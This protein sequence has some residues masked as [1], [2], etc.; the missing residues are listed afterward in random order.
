MIKV[1]RPASFCCLFF[2]LWIHS[3]ALVAVAATNSTEES[4]WETQAEQND[5]LNH[6][7]QNEFSSPRESTTTLKLDFITIPLDGKISPREPICPP[8]LPA[9]ECFNLYYFT[10]DHYDQ[11]NGNRQ[12]ILYIGGGPGRTDTFF[13]RG[14]FSLEVNNNVIYFHLRGAGL[15]V[16]PPSN[17]YD[18]YLR[19]E[20]AVEDLERLRRK[21]LATSPG[22][23][24][25]WDAV[26]GASYG[27]VLA[28]RYAN[29]YPGSIKKL[30]LQSPIYRSK[31]TD[32]ARRGQLRSNLKNMFT[33]IRSKE[34]VP[35]SCTNTNLS[36]MN[37][38]ITN[39]SPRD[40]DA[41]NNFC[42]L[43]SAPAHKVIDNLVE[44]V[45]QEYDKIIEEYGALSLIIE[46]FAAFKKAY[47]PSYPDEFYYALRKL[48][49]VGAP[50][51]TDSTFTGGDVEYMVDSALVLG[52]YASLERQE[53]LEEQ[54]HKFAAC[55]DTG[56]IF[57]NVQG[58]SCKELYCKRLT[59]AKNAV[60]NKEKLKL[61]IQSF[62]R[63]LYVFGL[64]DGLQQ[65]ITR[66]FREEGVPMTN[67]SCPLGKTFVD[68]AQSTSE[69]HKLLRQ[70][71]RKIGI[72]PVDKYCLWNPKNF[73]H[74][75]PTL[76]LTGGADLNTAGC[77][78]ED[79]F[80]HGLDKK[81]ST[82][83]EFPTLGHTFKIPVE[84]VRKILG[85]K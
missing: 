49:N 78:A 38:H 65:W 28:Q 42:Y 7:K 61:E 6:F 81:K 26:Y 22:Q 59:E 76:I 8:Q 58:A 69:S 52:Y 39:I 67:E 45:L 16:V 21:I 12:N 48:D 72:I 46:N 29:K 66:M 71:V 9:S 37:V 10:G 18:K 13:D 63:D 64:S 34:S 51:N 56:T 55:S 35:C 43:D 85:E 47:R 50:Q 2:I 84:I 20:Y 14:L 25:Q 74:G 32:K 82:F 79:F 80:D 19:S 60:G 15:S 23:A 4:F 68:F 24:K 75:L 27:T 77:Q 36:S 57:E 83:I 17:K 53:L 1:F 54:K 41:T 73:S 70:I 33:L 31:D 30:I 3:E 44:N 11:A 40:F 5:R 62:P